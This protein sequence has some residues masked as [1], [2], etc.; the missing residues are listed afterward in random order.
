MYVQPHPTET[1]PRFLF[2]VLGPWTE[3]STTT[4]STEPFTF[5]WVNDH[6]VFSDLL[7]EKRCLSPVWCPLSNI[8]SPPT[9]RVTSDKKSS[10]SP[11][12]DSTDSPGNRASGSSEPLLANE[13]CAWVLSVII[14]GPEKKFLS[15]LVLVFHF[16]Y[17]SS[18]F[19]AIGFE[20]DAL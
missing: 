20:P 17:Y 7:P 10:R 11:L 12:V 1:S 8:N 4:N 2:Y 9:A 3:A 14:S 19:K 15:A 18:A 6:W 5:P 13:F 16:T